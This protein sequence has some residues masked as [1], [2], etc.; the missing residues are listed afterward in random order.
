MFGVAFVRTL[1]PNP[2]VI[3]NWSFTNPHTTWQHL[4]Q[5]LCGPEVL[6]HLWSNHRIEARVFPPG[7]FVKEHR[8]HLAGTRYFYACISISIWVYRGEMWLCHSDK[9]WFKRSQF[10]S[11][12]EQLRQLLLTNSKDVIKLG[13]RFILCFCCLQQIDFRNICT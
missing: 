9:V 13:C 7:S 4:Y 2:F 8:S 3:E 10:N 1:G 12:D 5:K 11:V 6:L